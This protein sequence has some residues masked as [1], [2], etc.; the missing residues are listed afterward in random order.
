MVVK[1]P[2]RLLGPIGYV[3]P[4]Y[5]ESYFRAQATPTESSQRVSDWVIAAHTSTFNPG[6]FF[7]DISQS[8]R[9]NGLLEREFGLSQ[10]IRYEVRF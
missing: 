4:E 9:G 1:L 2:P 7:S 5:E 10:I 6:Y 8:T 3:P